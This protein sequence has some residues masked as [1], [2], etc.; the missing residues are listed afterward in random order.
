MISLGIGVARSGRVPLRTKAAAL[1]TEWWRR[2]Q[3]RYEIERLTERE[4]ADMWLTR[5]DT[6]EE[7]QKPFWEP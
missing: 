3:S 1:F 4:L 6:V 2:V 5:L 7:M